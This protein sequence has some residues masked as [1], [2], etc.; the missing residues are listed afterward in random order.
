MKK[1]G[2]ECKIFY[3]KTL[4]SNNVLKPFIKTNINNAIRCAKELVCLPSNENLTKKEIIKITKTVN[5]F[6]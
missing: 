4:P 3:S 2:I 6:F 5:N 1:K